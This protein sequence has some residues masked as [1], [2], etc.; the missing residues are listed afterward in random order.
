MKLPCYLVQDLLPLYKDNVCDPQTAHD[1]QE[2]LDDCAACSAL[3]AEMDAPPME[4]ALYE[5]QSTEAAAALS[6]VKKDLR[7]RQVKIALAVAGVLLTLFAL[8]SGWKYWMMH[9]YID[10]PAEDLVVEEMYE[11]L[12]PDAYGYVRTVK[13]NAVRNAKTGV[14]YNTVGYQVR[15]Y[16]DAPVAF[17]S[18]TQTRWEDLMRRFSKNNEPIW[19]EVPSHHTIFVTHDS[20]LAIKEARLMP[21]EADLL[22]PLVDDVTL[23]R[24]DGGF[25]WEDSAKSVSAILEKIRFMKVKLKKNT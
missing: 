21:E 12:P 14:Y 9:S 4:L 18:I 17:M 5:E 6:D 19:F 24:Y 20:Y 22:D 16:L 13:K 15:Y 3:L 23:T 25:L 10:L 8:F 11:E 7:A 2:H 1:V